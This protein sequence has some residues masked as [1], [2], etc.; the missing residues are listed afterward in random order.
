[1]LVEISKIQVKNRI[2]KDCGDI[3]GLAE[4]IRKLG[5]L[6]SIVL[7]PELVLIAGERRLRAAKRLGWTEIEA[8]IKTTADREEELL[9]E[10]AE[11]ESHKEF[12]ASERVAYGIELEQ[13]ERLKAEE[14][15]RE[16][17]GTAP[18][19]PKTLCDHGRTVNEETGRATD[20]IAK[21][22]GLGSGKNYERLKT[23]INNG[24]Q[25]LIEKVDKKEIGVRTACDLIK[26]KKQEEQ[27]KEDKPVMQPDKPEFE[28]KE[29]LPIMQSVPEGKTKKE[30]KEKS[31]S[32]L[33]S[34]EIKKAFKDILNISQFEDSVNRFLCETGNYQFCSESYKLLTIPEKE[35]MARNVFEIESWL[36]GIKKAFKEA[37]INVKF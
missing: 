3:D 24:D 36:K 20:I 23:I 12:T 28:E 6:Q 22:V 14:R 25:E 7:T 18:G 8:S 32:F 1:M 33:D 34:E 5:L 19:K 31:E 17:G 4:S 11:N 29:E 9:C 26:A 16:H 21:K 2:R 35:R 30:V 10:I 15:K 37:K 27:K 13:V